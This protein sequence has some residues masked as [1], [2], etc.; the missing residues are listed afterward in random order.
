MHLLAKVTRQP[1]TVFSFVLQAS[2]RTSMRQGLKTKMPGHF[3]D[4]GK[5]P[6]EGTA[7]VNLPFRITREAVQ[8]L[9]G[10]LELPTPIA[11][12]FSSVLVNSVSSANT[13][14]F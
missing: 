8:M 14:H 12:S 4:V 5:S 3:I 2:E 13:T 7:G 1:Q 11:P 10:F 6:Q 9:A